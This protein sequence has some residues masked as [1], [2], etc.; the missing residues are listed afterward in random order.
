MSAPVC[1]SGRRACPPE[2]IGGIGGYA[3]L[4]DRLAQGAAGEDGDDAPAFTDFD[5]AEFHPE[6]VI[7]MDPRARF[8]LMR[9]EG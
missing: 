8:R 3:A 4:L 7:F 5:P 1:L 9:E 6:G 2:D